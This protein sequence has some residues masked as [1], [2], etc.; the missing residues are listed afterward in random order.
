MF[1]IAEVS[2]TVQSL[3]TGARKN[4]TWF[5]P[6]FSVALPSRW[7]WKP[8]E[9]PFPSALLQ[10]QMTG[11][12]WRYGWTFK[13]FAFPMNFRPLFVSAW[14]KASYQPGC[15]SLQLAG[16]PNSA[17]SKT[18]AAFFFS[19]L[20]TP[21]IHFIIWNLRKRWSALIP[22]HL[23]VA[24]QSLEI[25]NWCWLFCAVPW[26]DLCLYVASADGIN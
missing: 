8:H 2:S 11:Q 21:I 26:D 18:G 14:I 7:S 23:P 17:V 1:R 13:V 20:I 22:G 6:Y 24:A 25:T 12:L 9:R 4:D 16:S 19:K 15:C 5:F 10:W 3:K